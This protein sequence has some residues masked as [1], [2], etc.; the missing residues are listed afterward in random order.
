MKLAVRTLMTAVIGLVVFGAVVFGAAGTLDYP[1]GWAFLAVYA[2]FTNVIGVY[3]AVKDPALLARRIRVGPQ[4]ETRPAQKA[5][6]SVFFAGFV[7]LVVVSVLDHR[8]GWSHVPVWVSVLGNALVALG[9]LIDLRVFR[10]NSYG[11][12][13]VR[14]ME[15]QRV[16]STGPYAL[17]RHP[18]YVGVLFLLV[19]IPLALGSYWGLVVSLLHVP[20]LMFRIVDEESMLRRDLSGYTDYT[21]S[22]RYRLVPGLW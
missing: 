5:L 20:L 7:A 9:L 16:I 12:S 2:A 1:R 15:G 3:L 11:A 8:F 14:V 17:V 19:G 13:T 4:A 22:V 21:Q 6:I 10:E 18:M